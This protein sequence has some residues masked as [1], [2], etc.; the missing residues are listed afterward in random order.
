M[1]GFIFGGKTGIA[2]PE[3]LARRRDLVRAIRTRNGGAVA[4]DPWEGLN[5]VADA[6]GGRLEESR[7]SDAEAAGRQGA[8]EKFQKYLQGGLG[9]TPQADVISD[10]WMSESQREF[11]RLH[12]PQQKKTIP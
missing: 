5:A 8:D 3:E 6:I 11:L 12:Y 1:A 9:S 10:P 4:Q 7:I 2:T